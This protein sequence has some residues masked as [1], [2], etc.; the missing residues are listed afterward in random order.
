M[1]DVDG[2]TRRPAAEQ[3][4]A[5]PFENFDAFHAVQGMRK[6]AEFVAVGKSIAIDLRVQ[7]ADQKV[8][9]V[10]LGILTTRVDAAGVVD[11]VTQHGGAL[12]GQERARNDLDAAG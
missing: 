7:A 10:T 3:G 2:A 8:V 5:R 1:D 4:R 11:G 12:L 9:V 6:S